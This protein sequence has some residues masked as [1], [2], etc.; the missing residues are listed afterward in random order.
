MSEPERGSPL[1]ALGVGDTVDVHLF[2]QEQQF[3]ERYDEPE[4]PAYVPPVAVLALLLVVPVALVI[5]NLLA[6]VPGHR[7]AHL[8]P[9]DVLRTE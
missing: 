7:A 8:H 5:A 1:E 3:A 9:A 4:G 2:T 6:A